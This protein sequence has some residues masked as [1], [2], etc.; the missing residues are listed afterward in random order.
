MARVSKNDYLKLLQS[1]QF[2]DFVIK[3]GDVE[4]KVHKAV[5]ATA[6]RMLNVACS[7]PFEVTSPLLS[8]A[9]QQLN[10]C[11]NLKLDAS[12]SMRK[13]PVSWAE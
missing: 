5:V 12:S 10:R 9:L 4:Y 7:G 2:S 13:I 6:S 11:R 1:G 8:I 3:C